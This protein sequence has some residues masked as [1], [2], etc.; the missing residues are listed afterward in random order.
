MEPQIGTH[1]KD[2]QYP[3]DEEEES[4]VA[5]QVDPLPKLAAGTQEI[6]ATFSTHREEFSQESIKTSITIVRVIISRNGYLD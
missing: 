2:P 4:Q 3:P 6:P 1:P 5:A